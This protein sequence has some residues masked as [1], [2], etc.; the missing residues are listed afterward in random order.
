MII[1]DIKCSREQELVFDLESGV[2]PVI[3]QTK[4]TRFS[5]GQNN[6]ALTR[7]CNS[8]LGTDGAINTERSVRLE[9]S[10]SI[11]LVLPLTNGE[12]PVN[13]KPG[14][15]VKMDLLEKKATLEKPKKKGCKKPPKPPRP[16]N[17]R[18]LDAFDQKLMREISEIEMLKQAR[19]ER[20]KKTI[21]NARSTS[22]IRNFW[23]L[24][25]SIL[26]VLIVIWQGVVSRGGSIISFYSSPESLKKTTGGLI[27]IR[28][29]KNASKNVHTF[30]SSSSRYVPF[31]M[32]VA[33]SC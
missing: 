3:K 31:M 7:V 1:M 24:L 10:S 21:K 29:Y 12:T 16:S 23:A 25:I 32:F 20:M 13:K 4:D 6:G 30:S 26:F 2:N 8:I 15:E 22:Y 27:S 5:S 19:I 9:D 14:A 17:S 18:S 11:S 33:L 28:L